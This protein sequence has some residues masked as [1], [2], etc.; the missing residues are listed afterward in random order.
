[1]ED[2]LHH[3]SSQFDEE[4]GRLRSD[5]LRMGGL[6]EN[7]VA[8]AIE[9]Y[10]ACDP[11]AIEETIARDQDIN[12][13]EKQI[14]DESAQLIARRQPTAVDLRLVFGI[15]KIVTDLERIGDE[16]K[17]IAKG[18]RRICDAGSNPTQFAPSIRQLAKAVMIMTRESLDAFARLDSALAQKVIVDDDGVDAE[19]KEILHRLVTDMIDDNTTIGLAMDIIWIA[20][21]V[22]RIGD[23]AK[24]VAEHVIF[25]VDGRDVRHNAYQID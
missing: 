7:Q 4:L 17:K 24:N 18:V 14:D 25:I 12:A 2:I 22:E 16:A 6:V 23:H 13:L 10:G 3:Q 15:I 5:V 1:M 11:R 9:A 20:R 19:Y 8:T 21:A